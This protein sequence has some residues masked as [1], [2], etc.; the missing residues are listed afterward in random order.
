MECTVRIKD[1]LLE[2]ARSVMGDASL[3]EIIDAG[4]R[5]LIRTRQLQEIASQIGNETLVDLTVDELLKQRA[6]ETHRLDL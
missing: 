4:L 5:E 6:R 2:E 1:E 3:D